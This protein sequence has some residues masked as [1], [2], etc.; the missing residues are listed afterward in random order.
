MTVLKQFNSHPERRKLSEPFETEL[1]AEEETVLRNTMAN[2]ATKHLP[3]FHGLSYQREEMSRPSFVRKVKFAR[4]MEEVIGSEP[5]RKGS[6]VA[7]PAETS[8]RLTNVEKKL[9][10]FIKEKCQSRE[11]AE[12][13]SRPVKSEKAEE[14]IFIKSKDI[15]CRVPRKRAA[16]RTEE[17]PHLREKLRDN[18]LAVDYKHEDL[19]RR[20]E[21][22]KVVIP[23]PTLE[24]HV[25]IAE[26]SHTLGEEEGES[27]RREKAYV[28]HNSKRYR[29][30]K[31]CRTE[32]SAIDAV[33]KEDSPEKKRDTANAH[34][35]KIKSN[36][37]SYKKFKASHP[38]L[39][40]AA[41][42]ESEKSMRPEAE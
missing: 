12:A 35:F 11:E 37:T 20:P 31:K 13:A 24:M 19:F 23:I 36:K 15:L 5:A 40:P 1:T 42:K 22:I 8:K 16:S 29:G 9:R 18:F 38:N 7:S 41:G 6:A 4:Q 33:L 27:Q 3:D 39:R 10:Q 26:K 32:E 28:I 30:V 14:S 21:H 2:S 17:S 25:S 34:L